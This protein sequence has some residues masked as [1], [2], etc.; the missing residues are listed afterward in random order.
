MNAPE[1]VVFGC[2]TLDNVVTAEGVCLPQSFGGNCLYA[3]LGARLWCDRVGI[4]SRY[5]ADYPGAVFELLRETGID[6]AGLA[7]LDR[8][9]GRNMAF[10]Y[11]ADGSRTRAIPPEVLARIPPR[12]R[13][14]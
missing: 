10:A 5:G 9:H 8:P 1:L 2:L 12:E 6:A 13:P 7:R 3:V 11:R 14:R 4:V